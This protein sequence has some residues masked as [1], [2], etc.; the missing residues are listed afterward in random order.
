MSESAIKLM[1]PSPFEEARRYC[2]LRGWHYNGTTH[3][4][5]EGGGRIELPEALADYVSQITAE[6]DELRRVL[7]D[8]FVSKLPEPI[9]LKVSPAPESARETVDWEPKP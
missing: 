4:S 2:F 7:A 9:I 3:V 5:F 1:Q 8:S 6:R